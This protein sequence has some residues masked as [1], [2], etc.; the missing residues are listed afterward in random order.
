MNHRELEEYISLHCDNEPSYLQRLAHDANVRLLYT[1]MMSGHVQ[2][3][4]L[5][6]LVEM[7]RPS[8]V[9]EIGTFAGYATLCMAEG[10]SPDAFIDTVEIDDE[11]EDFIREHFAGSPFGNRIRLH[12]GDALE[13]VPSLA[14]EQKH[15]DLIF[16]DADKRLYPCY[17]TMLKPLIAKGGWLIADNTLWSGK[18]TVAME[19]AALRS[20]DDQLDGIMTFNE[21]VAN[22]SDVEKVILPLRDGLS[23]IRKH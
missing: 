6:M 13:I 3:R 15:W 17:Y 23:I 11:I 5:K 7:I 18:V 8:S 1:R 10:L 4:F 19:N 2:G 22:D 16:L 14:K 20:K 12:I 9:L 21:M